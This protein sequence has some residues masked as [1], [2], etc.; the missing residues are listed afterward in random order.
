MKSRNRVVRTLSVAV[1]AVACFSISVL[2]FAQGTKGDIA[3][4]VRTALGE[5]VEYDY[6][7][8]RGLLTEVRVLVQSTLNS[9]DLA[10]PV[11]EALVE[12]LVSDANFAGKQFVCEQLSLIGTKRAVPT[13]T[14]LLSAAETADIALYALQR[15]PESAAGKAL[16]D[17]LGDA[18]GGAKI[19]II[20]ALGERGDARSVGAIAKLLYHDDGLTAESAA[21][22]LGKL[23]S[24]TAA[25]AL[26]SAASQTVGRV[27]DRVLDAYLLCADAYHE[28]DATAKAL[29]IYAELY[30]EDESDRVQAAALRGV[31]KSSE[32]DAAAGLLVAAFHRD[33]AKILDVAIGLLRNIPGH[34]DLNAIIDALPSFDAPEQVQVLAALA[35]RREKSA[36]GA[37]IIA[38]RHDDENV[39]AAALTALASIG[40]EG[41]ITLLVGA[42]SAG[43]GI[44][45][46]AAKSALDRMPG[47]GI[48]HRII[49]H[50]A[51]ADA[52]VR[53]EL[54]RSLGQRN[55]LGA[56]PTLL[57]TATDSDRNVRVE[58]YKA[59]A[60]VSPPQAIDALIQLLI[61]EEHSG[62]RTQAKTTVKLVA[63]KA[64]GAVDPSG[65]VLAALTGVGDGDARNSLLEVLGSIGSESGLVFLRNELNSDSSEN[66]KA[67]IQALSVWPGSEPR[68]DL[69][70]I[71]KRTDNPAN[72]SLALRGY[73]GLLQN[74]GRR[75]GGDDE[76]EGRGRRGQG[77]ALVGLYVGAMD[78][79]TEVSEKRLVLSA[80]GR[81]QSVEALTATANYIT[82]SRIQA[83]VEAALM[84]PVGEL[85]DSDTVR[86]KRT[87]DGGLRDT[88]EAVLAVAKNQRLRQRVEEIL[89]KGK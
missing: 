55:A 20:N 59:L 81:M 62:V 54:V 24:G 46:V 1:V 14:Q 15:I 2:S 3:A 44:D 64:T 35:H 49:E 72:R 40:G 37:V 38:T 42:A 82:D 63:Q 89:T 57:R 53:A 66:Q 34:R 36:H 84:R 65:L 33:N 70:N 13:L 10:G 75:R 43:S 60:I 67:A 76:D 50:I 12:F 47:E 7:G 4:A 27:R 30:N 39:R 26:K 31:L 28:E 41:D 68:E 58:S 78:L 88:L 69:R 48:N 5:M 74:S 17:A 22:S 73:I 79:A 11:E 32:D 86:I 6:G 83:E 71:V 19:G 18:E 45:S 61:A 8:D 23:A 51:Q 25:K 21:N 87:L 56:T 9:D 80:L 77:S 29:A 16:R 52:G 85:R